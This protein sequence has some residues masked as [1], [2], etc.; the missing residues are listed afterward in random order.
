MEK[1]RKE[2]QASGK[3]SFALAWVMDATSEERSRGVTVDV[4]TNSFS[5]SQTNFTILDA[6]GHRDFVPNMIAGASQA[7]F[8]VLVI[9]AS[10]NSFESG[11]RGQ[12]KEHALLARSLGISRLLIAVNKMD[13]TSWSQERFEEISQQMRAFLTTAGFASKNLTF[14][15]CAGLTGEN[16]VDPIP[17]DAASWYSGPTLLA[18]LDSFA[19]E[20]SKR[21]LEKPAR[22]TI[23][24]IFSDASLRVS[25]RLDAGTLQ[26]GDV[27][28]AQ[29]SGERAS[30]RSIEVDSDS[31]DWCVAGQLPTLILTGIDPV[32]LRLGDILCSPNTP[33]PNIKSFTA[34]ILTFEHVM[35]GY[36]DVHKGRLNAEGKISKLVASLDKATGAVAK[37]KPRVLQPG[38]AARVVIEMERALPLEA[39][40]RMVLRNEGNT[41]A[42]GLIESV[43]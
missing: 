28:L 4:A 1:L 18:A 31:A 17:Q 13:T 30:I 39:G 3:S 24:E 6:P 19:S 8:A 35:P 7:D 33:V 11:L 10:T 20:P 2:A 43:E 40:N 32:H 22:L 29:P 25:G 42:S 36:V 14:I 27:L 9:D 15:P 5:T 21:A 34:K 41:V 37:K 12:T 26:V 23:S 16:I 38:S